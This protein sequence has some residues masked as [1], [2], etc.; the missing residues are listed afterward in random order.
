ML[1]GLGLALTGALVVTAWAQNPVVRVRG[2]VE[3]LSGGKLTV[4]TV[5]GESLRIS[6][7]E[8]VMVVALKKA[9]MGA[10]KTGSYIA[11]TSVKTAAAQEAEEVM[12]FLESGRGTA[13][14][15]FPWDQGTGTMMTNANVNAEV[16]QA[17]GREL[18]LSPKG[19]AMKI[20]VP[21]RA[22]IVQQEL[23]DTSLL[24]PGARVFFGAQKAA[25]G[26]LSAGRVYVGKGCAP[27]KAW[28][29]CK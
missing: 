1:S 23:A 17:N 15:H 6:L 2:D 19:Q 7:A 12:V 8:K 3:S 9:D 25:D 16:Q 14:G 18:T 21:A 22:V 10:I 4:K 20:T 24:V 29:H 5:G 27:S 26:S 11:T 28:V 13:E